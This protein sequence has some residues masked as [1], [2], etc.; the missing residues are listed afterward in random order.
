M[1][2]PLMW[3]KECLE[4]LIF[5]QKLMPLFICF[6]HPVETC[7]N[8]EVCRLK[9]N[10][11]PCV[12]YC[13]CRVGGGA[14]CSKLG[15]P[16]KLSLSSNTHAHHTVPSIFPRVYN[17]WSRECLRCILLHRAILNRNGR[18]TSS[19]WYSEGSWRMSDADRPDMILQEV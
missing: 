17:P 2:Y 5:H 4:T 1:Y 12:L 6:L 3:L 15:G 9:R 8:T 7:G 13:S 11:W 10:S 14:Q 19:T 16:R 18:L